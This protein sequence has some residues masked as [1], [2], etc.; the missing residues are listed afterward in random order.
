MSLTL[1]LTLQMYAQKY[2]SWKVSLSKNSF[3]YEW[4]TMNMHVS[5][6]TN[7]SRKTIVCKLIDSKNKIIKYYYL[8]K[9][10]NP[11]MSKPND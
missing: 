11:Q 2:F 8:E 10:L 9:G 6:H 1:T 5:E 4:N 7:Y 3:F